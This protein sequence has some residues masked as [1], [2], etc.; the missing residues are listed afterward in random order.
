MDGGFEWFRSAEALCGEPP[1]GIRELNVVTLVRYCSHDEL[2]LLAM[3]DEFDRVASPAL[4]ST[5]ANSPG[6]QGPGA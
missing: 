4:G 1:G 2:Q 5:Q 6:C 3:R